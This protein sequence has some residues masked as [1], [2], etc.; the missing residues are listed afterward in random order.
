MKERL[1]VRPAVTEAADKTASV[2]KQAERF[3]A[4]KLEIQET[5]EEIRS[6]YLVNT[7]N[8]RVS[9][10]VDV[11]FVMADGTARQTTCTWDGEVFDY[12][13][14]TQA[15]FEEGLESTAYWMGKEYE[16]DHGYEVE[17]RIESVVN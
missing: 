15:H 3:L 13:V 6:Y 9:G 7:E 1:A 14:T 16:R 11:L 12:S 8:E 4:E 5:Y 10:S 17:Y 2:S